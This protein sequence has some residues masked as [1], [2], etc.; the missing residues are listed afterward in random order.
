MGWM[1]PYHTE[2]RKTL[3][4]DRVKTFEDENVKSEVLRHCVRGNNLW[5][6]MQVTYKTNGEVQ[7]Y[8][9]LDMMAK[10]DGVWGYKDLDDASGPCYYNCPLSYVEACTELNVGYATKWRQSVREYWADKR[11]K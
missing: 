6:L 10:S 9:A 4:A 3:I 8:V 5:K 11:K 1:F 2:E 7:R